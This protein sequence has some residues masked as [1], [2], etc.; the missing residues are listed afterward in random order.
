M[1]RPGALWRESPHDGRGSIHHSDHGSQDLQAHHTGRLADAEL[2]PC[3]GPIGDTCNTALGESALGLCKAEVIKPPAPWT[4]SEARRVGNHPPGRPAHHRSPPRRHRLPTTA[5]AQARQPLGRYRQ[6]RHALGR[7]QLPRP[8]LPA[9]VAN[10][11][12]RRAKQPRDIR[13]R[14][15]GLSAPLRE[16]AALFRRRRPPGSSIT[17]SRNT[18][19]RPAARMD[20]PFQSPHLQRPFTRS[21]ARADPQRQER[22]GL[23]L[24]GHLLRARPYAGTVRPRAGGAVRAGRRRGCRRRRSRG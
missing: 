2:A 13:H 24:T 15:A 18:P 17:A 11:P 14:G 9:P 12:A 23:A 20:A 4:T 16:G 3:V 7:H 8:Q 6:R 22:I 21:M 19:P 1:R 5:R 10:L